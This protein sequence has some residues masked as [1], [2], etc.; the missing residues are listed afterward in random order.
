MAPDRPA[1]EQQDAPRRRALRLGPFGRPAEDR[2]AA[3]ARSGRRTCAPLQVCVQ[4]NVSGEATRA[5][6][7]RPTCRALAARGRGA[8]AASPARPDGDPRAA[9]DGV[10]AQRG[11]ASRAAPAVRVDLRAQGLA[12]DTLSMGMSDDL[13]AA[14][15]EGA[16]WC[17]SAARSSATRQVPETAP[18]A[19]RY[20]VSRRREQ[21]MPPVPLLERLARP[22][23]ARTWPLPFGT[24]THGA[25]K[26]SAGFDDLRRLRQRRVDRRGVRVHEL[27]PARVPRARARCRISTQNRRSA[28]ER[29]RA[30][31]RL[32]QDRVIAAEV[33]L[34]AHLQRRR[35]AAEVDRVAAAARR[36]AADRAVAVH[37]RHGAVRF[38]AEAHGAAMAGAFEVHGRGREWNRIR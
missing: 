37:E 27:R 21:A 3:R 7:R 8:A 29:L 30:L 19:P 2:R 23:A 10:E 14:I 22:L 32:A 17:A 16:T 15:A 4:V 28:F 18:T 1:A 38:E 34:A 35:G 26:S 12:L 31:A 6:W 9:A 33:L 25:T 13:E 36:L 5:A 24:S 20:A 11:A